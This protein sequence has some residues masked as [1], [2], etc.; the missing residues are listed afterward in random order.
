MRLAAGVEPARVA[1]HLRFCVSCLTG[2]PRLLRL[3]ARLMLASSRASRSKAELD[4]GAG[5]ARG[6][7]KGC[8][9]RRRVERHTMSRHPGLLRH[10]GVDAGV[11]R[12]EDGQLHRRR[13]PRGRRVV[14]EGAGGFGGCG[15]D[16]LS[17]AGLLRRREASRKPTVQ[18]LERSVGTISLEPSLIRTSFCSAP[19]RLAQDR[20]LDPKAQPRGARG[21]LPYGWAGVGAEPPQSCV[22]V[23]LSGRG[24][25]GSGM[26]CEQWGPPWKRSSASRNAT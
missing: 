24:Q 18:A 5:G 7:P 2:S 26:M 20:L 14:E 25:R 23:A 9:A 13:A 6:C 1:P 17:T 8:G 4:V 10:H 19:P 12:A 22:V 21:G 3:A 16:N 11:P 15:K